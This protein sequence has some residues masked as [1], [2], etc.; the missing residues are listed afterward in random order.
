MEE[1]FDLYVVEE[2]STFVGMI[3]ICSAWYEWVCVA[4]ARLYCRALMEASR[5][6]LETTRGHWRTHCRTAAGRASS[7]AFEAIVKLAEIWAASQRCSEVVVAR[8]TGTL[9]RKGLGS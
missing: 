1:A 6:R 9:L 5:G 2:V 3:D 8:V 7:V 4:M